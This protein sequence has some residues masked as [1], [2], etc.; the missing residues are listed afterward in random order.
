MK[1][2][3]TAKT[4]ACMSNILLGKVR[5]VM[6]LEVELLRKMPDERV[7]EWSGYPL[8]CYDYYSTCGAKNTDVSD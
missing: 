7:G 8:D 6:K 5:T 2:L 4:L 3:Y 1:L